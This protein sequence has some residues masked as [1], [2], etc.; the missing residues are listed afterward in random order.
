VIGESL[1]SAAFGLVVAGAAFAGIVALL[2]A[3]AFVSL[4]R[5]QPVGA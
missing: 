3:I 2:G 4:L 5:Q 1:A